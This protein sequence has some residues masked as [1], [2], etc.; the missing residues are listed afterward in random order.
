M[1]ERYRSGG[2]VV[3]IFFGF[4]IFGFVVFRGWGGACSAAWGVLFFFVLVFGV[5]FVLRSTY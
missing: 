4:V 2:G 1:F 3:G 5:S